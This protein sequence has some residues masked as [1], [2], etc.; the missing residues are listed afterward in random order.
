MH[1]ASIGSPGQVGSV[2][3]ELNL[4]TDGS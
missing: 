2:A 4:T 1:G 3:L